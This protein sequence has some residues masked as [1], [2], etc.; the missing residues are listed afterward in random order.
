ME[1]STDAEDDDDLDAILP[2]GMAMA[3]PQKP[4][5]APEKC[6]ARAAAAQKR[7]RTA[8]PTKKSERVRVPPFPKQDIALEE[9]RKYAPEGASLWMSK[10]EGNWQGHYKL[11]F[12]SRVSRSW[13]KYGESIALKLTLRHLWEC[14]CKHHGLSRD[15]CGIE[16]LWDDDAPLALAAGSSSAPASKAT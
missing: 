1:E 12:F 9:A 15:A 10:A 11:G 3:A 2:M 16:G 7:S 13:K 8:S 6:K 14:H 4:P 5:A